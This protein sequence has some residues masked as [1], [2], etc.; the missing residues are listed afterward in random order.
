MFASL[1]RCS[2]S[3]YERLSSDLRI[4]DTSTL[5]WSAPACAAPPVAASAAAGSVVSDYSGFIRGSWSVPRCE[6]TA[7]LVGKLMYVVGGWTTSNPSINVVDTW[8]A[9]SLSHTPKP[10]P[11]RTRSKR[12][13]TA[14][15]LAA[16]MKLQLGFSFSRALRSLL[17]L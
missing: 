16:A 17:F 12:E 9:L 4:L 13:V 15:W 2:P 10:K 11:K 14:A 5:T 6:H 8:S 1:P 7:T 3:R